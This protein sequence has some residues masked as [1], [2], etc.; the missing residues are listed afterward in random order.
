MAYDKEEIEKD[1][2]EFEN[3]DFDLLADFDDDIDE[4]SVSDSRYIKPKKQK[5]F[6]TN[7]IKFLNAQKLAK[8]IDLKAKENLF[9]VVDGSFVFGDFLLA[10]LEYHDIKAKRIDISTLSLSMHNIVGLE[11]FIK[12]GY[13]ENL[14][15]LIGYYFY[16]HEKKGLMKAVYERLDVDNR[17]QVAVCRNHTKCATI[18]TDR[19]NKIVIHGS[20]N[21][22][23]SDNLEQFSLEFSNEKYDFLTEFN[24]KILNEFKTIQKPL[25]NKTVINL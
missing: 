19:G 13:I 5:Q 24:E 12:K 1:L 16:A 22:R 2:N 8:K 23:S 17:L 11:T 25:T 14:N 3:N 6:P 7:Y 21:L 20:A 9:C 18:L 4:E 10:F 15:F